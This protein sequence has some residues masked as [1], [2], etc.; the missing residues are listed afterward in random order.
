[1]NIDLNELLKYLLQNFKILKNPLTFIYEILSD[2]TAAPDVGFPSTTIVDRSSKYRDI[3]GIEKH[4]LKV[5]AIELMS[6]A[7]LS[8]VLPHLIFCSSEGEVIKL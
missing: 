3:H 7:K 4:H 6:E 5:L 2:L 8:L 1:M